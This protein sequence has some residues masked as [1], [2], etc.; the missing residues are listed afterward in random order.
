MGLSTLILN[1]SGTIAKI[2]GRRVLTAAETL[3]GLI[4]AAVA[5]EMFLQG[6]RTFVL[7]FRC[8]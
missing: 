8:P 1:S 5:V 7:T 3:M 4:L 2:V 6:I